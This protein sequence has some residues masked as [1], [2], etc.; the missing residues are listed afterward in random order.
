MMIRIYRVN[1]SIVPYRPAY[2]YVVLLAMLLA[3]SWENALN[4]AVIAS[5]S[6]PEEAIR[7]RI[8]A[9]SDSAPDQ[10][11]KRHVREAVAGEL[12]RLT[13]GAET[14]G[15]ARKAL[16]AA[17]PELEALATRELERRGFG[18]GAA[19]ELGRVP[20]PAKIYGN[21]LYP[22]G[23]YEALLITLGKGRGENWWCVLFPPLCFADAVGADKAK[24][25]ESGP[26]APGH[27]PVAED[28]PQEAADA[29]KEAAVTA[30]ARA[31]AGAA[32]DAQDVEVK[33]A[34]WE[35]LQRVMGF[36]RRLFG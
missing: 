35:L 29:A 14:I 24:T 36:F 33:F 27:A 16:A 5:G 4:H 6:I 11:V 34:V 9:N 25:G 10:A 32:R 18:Y 8:L 12:R 13:A 15:E 21:R 28:G 30:G 20:F 2:G 1:P 22:A 23:E 31:S 26:D 19:V 3:I 7:L 17:L